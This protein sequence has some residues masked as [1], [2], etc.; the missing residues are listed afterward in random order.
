MM[1][2][3]GIGCFRVKGMIKD[4][5]YIFCD[6]DW[7]EPEIEVSGS[8]S[9]LVKLGVLLNTIV[10]YKLIK[11]NKSMSDF[12]LVN[13]DNLEIKV[14]NSRDSNIKIFINSSVLS[15]SGNQKTINK[16]GDSLINFFSGN[17]TSGEHFHLDYKGE[18]IY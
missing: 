14:S 5:I 11:L 3:N 7:N 8:S 2:L 12:Y 1:G 16:L 18:M 9:S 17:V 6:G 10:E 4:N 13:I 15:L